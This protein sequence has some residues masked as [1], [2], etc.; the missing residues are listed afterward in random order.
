MKTI[1]RMF[2]GILLNLAVGL[3]QADA[4]AD[5]IE[6]LSG[7][8]SVEARFSQVV[9]TTEGQLIQNLTGELKAQRPGRFRWHTD[10]PLEQEV[11]TDGQFVWFHD[12]DLEQVTVQ[13]LKGEAASTPALLFSGDPARIGSRYT[14]QSPRD[15]V[16]V[17]TPKE[18]SDLFVQLAIRFEGDTPVELEILDALGQRTRLTLHNV[19]LNPELPDGTFDFDPPEGVDI[20]RSEAPAGG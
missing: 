13:P 6:R 4:L 19:K 5:L 18:P 1:H 15:Q 9:T 14:V 11:V 3:A 20:I 16:F 7:I 12:P 2:L 10:P 8:Q 17:Q